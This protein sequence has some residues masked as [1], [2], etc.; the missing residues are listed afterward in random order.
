MMRT[1]YLFTIDIASL[2]KSVKINCA[3]LTKY[4]RI[5]CTAHKICKE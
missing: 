1:I 5:D 3:L 2:E 4:V